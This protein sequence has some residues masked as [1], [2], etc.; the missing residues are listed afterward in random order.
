MPERVS[1]IQQRALP[2]LALVAAHHA[3]LDL[4]GPADGARK[5]RRLALAQGRQVGDHFLEV[6]GVGEQPVLQDFRQAGGELARWQ[7]LQDIGVR[8]DDARLVERADQVLAVRMVDAGL[9][10]DR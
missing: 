5:R 2:R 10:A 3:C 8:H 6:P 4:A 1:E 9:A 7:R